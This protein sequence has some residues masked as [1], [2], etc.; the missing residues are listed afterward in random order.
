VGAVN[1]NG[2]ATLTTTLK[3]DSIDFR[4]EFSGLSS[5]LVQAMYSFSQ[6][7]TNGGPMVLLCGPVGSYAKQECPAATSGTV[8]GTLDA[9]NV[10]GPVAQNIGQGDLA[11]VEQAIRNQAA[12]L[13]LSTPMFPNE[14]NPR[15]V[16]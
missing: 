7:H 11:A 2:V 16:A 12:Y 9:S 10:V 15:P 1:T 13:N 14:R 5:N 6:E 8:S 3:Q 4:L